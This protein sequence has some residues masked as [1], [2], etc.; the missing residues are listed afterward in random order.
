MDI[1]P[2]LGHLISKSA[3]IILS[4]KEI[5]LSEEKVRKRKKNII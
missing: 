4:L 2:N 1:R 3:I 5:I